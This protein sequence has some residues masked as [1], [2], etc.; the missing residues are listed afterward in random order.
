MCMSTYTCVFSMMRAEA[1]FFEPRESS[2]FLWRLGSH[3]WA[4][5]GAVYVGR[6]CWS[7][8]ECVTVLVFSLPRDH[9]DIIC[10][11]Q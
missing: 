2:S 9:S 7:M 5:G 10:N 1:A 8:N 3:G 6:S 4:S 11:V